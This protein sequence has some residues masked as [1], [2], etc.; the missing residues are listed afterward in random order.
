MDSI[1]H[2]DMRVLACSPLRS[3][4]LCYGEGEPLSARDVVKEVKRR[5]TGRDG[6]DDDDLFPL[7]VLVDGMAVGGDADLLQRAS[8]GGDLLV[9]RLEESGVDGGKGGFGALLR[10]QSKLPGAKKTSDFSACR[11][12]SGRRLRHVNNERIMQKWDEA[13]NSG[14]E[15]DVDQE[16][17]SGI[18][19]WFL[20]VP[21]WAKCGF[22]KGAF[23][24]AYMKDRRKTTLCKE[25]QS[26]R[27]SRG[28][29]ASA[30]PWWGCPRGRR[31]EFAHGVDELR[32]ESQ[33]AAREAAA[34]SQREERDRARDAYFGVLLNGL[35]AHRDEEQLHDMVLEGMRRAKRAK[36]A[37]SSEEAAAALT[38]AASSVAA[39][40]SAAELVPAGGEWVSAVGLSDI[41]VGF[42]GEVEGGKGCAFSTAL[43]SAPLPVSSGPCSYY[44][45]VELLTEGLMQIGF[46][47]D[48]FISHILSSSSSSSSKEG[49]E[50]EVDVEGADGVGD[51][52]HSWAF[53]GLRSQK[54][55]VEGS[56]YPDEERE[57]WR[58]GDVVGCELLLSAPSAAGAV[59][60]TVSFA[61]NGSALG[62]A[63]AFPVDTLGPDAL[64]AFYPAV[65]LEDGEAL[66][67]NI[68]QHPFRHAGAAAR[69]PLDSL[70][71]PLRVR[72]VRDAL[73]SAANKAS[74]PD[75]T[76]AA[77]AARGPIDID[78]DEF[79]S[80]EKLM[81]AGAG[82]L[83]EELASR[84]LKCG[85]TSA[86]RAARLLAVRG[87]AEE[88]ID[89]KLR[90]P[91]K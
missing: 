72:A 58:A 89:P 33:A 45:E 67:V 76:S 88:D 48:K 18:N 74:S 5:E 2:H 49:E 1:S 64:V 22:K 35:G 29:P 24:R 41:M 15:F 85:G 17:S 8:G 59:C 32:G 54:W 75:P 34:Q 55:H 42:D 83:K 7:C 62:A 84:G 56:A 40:C 78:S 12:L 53:D 51:T 66:I 11:D 77:V 70:A 38:A 79:D 21:T 71:A 63:F 81:A 68:G 25:W 46:I 28:P 87:R 43:V 57:S 27:E 44:Y 60:V 16:T 13:K 19:M 9:V 52:A 69:R 20:G 39:G 26:A 50:E 61:H 80:L 65:S 10:I 47:D 14:K 36:V 3:H 73:V 91:K 90:A 86:E 37:P 31:C 23:R 6:S 30:P 82:R 4:L